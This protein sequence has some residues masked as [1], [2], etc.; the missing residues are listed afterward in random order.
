MVPACAFR[1]I[2]TSTMTLAR[3]MIPIACHQFMP[4][5]MS[6]EPCMYVVTHADME[7][8]STAMSRAPH[9]RPEAGTGAMSR[10]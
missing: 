3:K 6:D 8:H 7:I 5:A 9:F 2:G 10:L 1:T 4:S